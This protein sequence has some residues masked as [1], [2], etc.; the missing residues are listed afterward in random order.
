MTDINLEKL[1]AK[2]AE[3][4]TDDVSVTVD[5]TT[6]LYTLEAKDAIIEA[7]TEV[8]AASLT[9]SFNAFVKNVDKA[10]KDAA[11]KPVGAKK[12]YK[13]KAGTIKGVSHAAAVPY[14]QLSEDEVKAYGKEYVDPKGL[15]K[16]PKAKEDEDE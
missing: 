4:S 7:K 5:A 1:E 13:V 6:G 10:I 2:A 11:K 15:D 8:K 16:A 3:L 9:T 14:A 12:F